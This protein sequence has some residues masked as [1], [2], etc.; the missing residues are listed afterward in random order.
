MRMHFINP[1]R[2][3]SARSRPSGFESD[4]CVGLEGA[5]AHSIAFSTFSIQNPESVNIL[6]IGGIFARFGGAHSSLWFGC[7]LSGQR[8]TFSEQGEAIPANL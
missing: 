7:I 8:E 1:T 5:S 3:S 2:P 6:G 4:N